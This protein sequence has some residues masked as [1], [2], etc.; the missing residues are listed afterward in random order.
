MLNVEVSESPAQN[1][2]WLA[3]VIHGQTNVFSWSWR[4]KEKLTKVSQAFRSMVKCTGVAGVLVASSGRYQNRRTRRCGQTEQQHRTQLARSHWNKQW[5]SS[6]RAGQAS[7][8]KWTLSLVIFVT[9]Q[10]GLIG[11]L[12]DPLFT[13]RHRWKDDRA[14]MS[15]KRRHQSFESWW[16]Q[17]RR[18]GCTYL[19]ANDMGSH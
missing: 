8:M 17:Y 6:G 1:K 15:V 16:E 12:M 5:V 9:K 14:F 7:S 13:V 11:S 4:N 3:A 2:F 19:V 10:R 18:A